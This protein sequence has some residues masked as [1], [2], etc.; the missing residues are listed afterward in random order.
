[1]GS[2]VPISL[3][4]CIIEIRI[5]LSVIAFLTSPGLTI[6]YSS[7]GRYVTLNPCVSRNLQGSITAWCS[8]AEVII[9]LPFFLFASATPFIAKLSDSVPPLVKTISS[10]L[11]PTRFATLSLACSIASFDSLPNE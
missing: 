11:A 2:M 1:M 8:I 9:W 4:A 6:P 3:F 5:V 10:F 7:T